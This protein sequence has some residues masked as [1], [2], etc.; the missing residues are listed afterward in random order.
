MIQKIILAS[1]KRLPFNSFRVFAYKF[2][3]GYKI[4]NNTQIGKCVIK[5]AKVTIDNNVIIKDKN[6]IICNDL[7]I[8]D[9]VRIHSGNN[10]TGS[11]NF[12][13]G[14]NSRIINNHFIDLYNNVTLGSNTWLAGKDS[15]LWTHGS[16]HTKLGKDLS[17]NI[18]DNVYVGSNV[19]IAPGVKIA[20]LNLI[21]LGSVVT[22]NCMKTNNIIAGNPAK[23]VKGNMDWRIGW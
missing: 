17:I 22:E 15:Q 8:E 12:K 1:I 7:V 6:N 14:E 10:I 4:G 19:S 21:G 23:I 5:A 3:L 20:G 11:A 18:G 16:I 13:I 9:N 2:F